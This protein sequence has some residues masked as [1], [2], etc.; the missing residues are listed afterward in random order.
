MVYPFL[1][2]PGQIFD[3]KVFVVRGSAL[4]FVHDEKTLITIHD[5]LAFFVKFTENEPASRQIKIYSSRIS[6]LPVVR[7]G[8]Q[9][10][11]STRFFIISEPSGNSTSKSM[12]SLLEPLLLYLMLLSKTKVHLLEVSF[13]L[14]C[15]TPL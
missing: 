3:R 6:L 13:G 2:W 11:P 4:L 12:F 1:L 5:W 15:W 8:C 14:C 7:P 10:W 9:S